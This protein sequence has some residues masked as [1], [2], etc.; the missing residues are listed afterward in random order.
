MEPRAVRE[1]LERV[2][3]LLYH[4]SHP[5]GGGLSLLF[6][7]MGLASLRGALATL[8]VAQ[9]PAIANSLAICIIYVASYVVMRRHWLAGSVIVGIL[10]SCESRYHSSFTVGLTRSMAA[11]N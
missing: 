3:F 5:I 1:D 7:L 9:F 2:F 4:P 6:P 8:S 10:G 11:S